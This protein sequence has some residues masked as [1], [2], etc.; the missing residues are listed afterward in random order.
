MD[1]LNLRTLSQKIQSREIKAASLISDALDHARQSQC[2]F[3]GIDGKVLDDA[4]IIDRQLDSGKSLPLLSGIPIALKDLFDIQGQLTLAGSIVLKHYAKPASSDCEVLK[5]LRKSGLLFL[6]RTNMSEFA[7]SGLGINPHYGTP[8]SIWDRSEGRIP[9]GSSS[10]SA[11]SVA[12]GITPVSM[13]TDTA[14]S[15]RIPAAFNS[16]VGVKPS[17]GRF[18][19]KGVFPLSHSS[20]APGPIGMDVDSC[21]IVDQIISGDWD[22]HGEIPA[23]RSAKISELRLMIPDAAVFDDLDPEVE[24]CF[25]R[26]VQALR[27]AG[28]SIHRYPASVIDECV[29]LFLNRAIAGYEA[30]VLHRDMMQSHADEY[31]QSVLSRISSYQEVTDSEQQARY[32]AKRKLAQGFHDL[33]RQGKF[34]AMISPT[35]SCIPP[36]IAHASEQS[37]TR[38]VNLRCLRNTAIAN[39]FDGCSMSLPSHDYGTAPTGLMISSI[40]GDDARL[41]QIGFAVESTLNQARANA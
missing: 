27:D 38:S 1:R 22:G 25:D 15:C 3:T 18:S 19:L 17:Y 31:D 36:M 13:G 30:Y 24:N 6:G 34:D 5:P 9:G 10:G 26:A 8:Q 14:G 32:A 28:A 40:N 23:I 29:D 11:V 35:V 20:D 39:N 33:M 37:R 4:E 16:V 2:L 12:E 21:Y 41:Y 7:F